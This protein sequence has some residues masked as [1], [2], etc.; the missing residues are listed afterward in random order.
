MLQVS[1]KLGSYKLSSA[2]TLLRKP[3]STCLFLARKLPSL[4][5]RGRMFVV[6]PERLHAVLPFLHVL[7]QFRCLQTSSSP[8]T[9]PSGCSVSLP[10]SLLLSRKKKRWNTQH[11]QSCEQSTCASFKSYRVQRISSRGSAF[12]NAY[13]HRARCARG[14]PRMGVFRIK[15]LPASVNASVFDWLRSRG[16]AVRPELSRLEREQLQARPPVLF[17]GLLPVKSAPLG[18]RLAERLN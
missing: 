1:N 4:H 14:H 10:H 18:Q 5:A 7:S 11:L 16:H 12:C 2:A 13:R 9:P 15:H 17:K 3:S 8:L 6:L